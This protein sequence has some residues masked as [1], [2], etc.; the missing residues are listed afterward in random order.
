MIGEW[1]DGGV[2]KRLQ[3]KCHDNYDSS[4]PSLH[5]Q[6]PQTSGGSESISRINALSCAYSPFK[7]TKGRSADKQ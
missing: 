4:M 5:I 7:W 1:R 3:H 6:V 2:K